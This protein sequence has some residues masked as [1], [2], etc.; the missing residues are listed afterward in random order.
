MRIPCNVDDMFL[1]YMLKNSLLCT[2]WNTQQ[3]WNSVDPVTRE[4]SIYLSFLSKHGPMD[5]SVTG[6]NG[7]SAFGT[8]V[9]G[10]IAFKLSLKEDIKMWND[11]LRFQLRK[12]QS[13]RNVE[14]EEIEVYL[15]LMNGRPKGLVRM[16]GKIPMEPSAFHHIMCREPGLGFIGHYQDG[17]LIGPSWQGLIGGGWIYGV[18][19]Q[20]GEFSGDNIAYIYPDNSTALLGEFRKGKMVIIKAVGKE[21]LVISLSH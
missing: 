11:Y 5:Y 9:N 2:A 1:Y 3:P 20:H 16:F 4:V 17:K 21:I 6:P 15:R 19:D 13:R 14:A 10:T 18:T 7:A 8:M 12:Q